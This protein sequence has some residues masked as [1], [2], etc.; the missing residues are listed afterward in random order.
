MVL[1]RARND[2][3]S[4]R[5]N[6]LPSWAKLG[7]SNDRFDK[8]LK[9]EGDQGTLAEIR[10]GLTAYTEQATPPESA[11]DEFRQASR[12]IAEVDKAVAML[13]DQDRQA[14]RLAL[15]GPAVQALTPAKRPPPARKPREGKRRATAFT[16]KSKK[17]KVIR[18]MPD[19]G[20]T[21]T[22]FDSRFFV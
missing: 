20:P 16:K 14:S 11:S 7:A 8:A 9:R 2:K 13:K 6:A 22:G 3:L 15:L 17:S 19:Q 5:A 4:A 1:R 21:G 18:V 12:R 10:S